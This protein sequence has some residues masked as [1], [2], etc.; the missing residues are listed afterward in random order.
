[1][2]GS[3]VASKNEKKM[4]AEEI[5]SDVAKM[6]GVTVEDVLSTKKHRAFSEC[7]TVI[8]YTLCRING[9]STLKAGDILNRTHPDIL[10]H[11]KKAED[12]LRMPR[13]NTDGN[14]AI[15][16]MRSKHQQES[17]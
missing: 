1:M 3:R 6:Y 5:I 12:W 7:R 4:R 9:L 14:T 13:L 11:L 16:E 10:Y 2:G 8:C 17:V 15:L